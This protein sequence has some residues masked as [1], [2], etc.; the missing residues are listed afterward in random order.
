MF[1]ES[2]V[3]DDY[4]ADLNRWMQTQGRFHQSVASIARCDIKALE[5]TVRLRSA[6]KRAAKDSA[7]NPWVHKAALPRPRSTR[8]GGNPKPSLSAYADRASVASLRKLGEE[9]LIGQADYKPVEFFERGLHVADSVGRINSAIGKS[10]TG[11]LVGEGILM[12]NHHVIGSPEEGGISALTMNLE[13]NIF[14]AVKPQEEFKL[15]PDAF[16]YTDAELDVTLVATSKR[17]ARGTEVTTFGYLPLIRAEGKILR[18]WNVNII[19]HPNEG[20]KVVS[21]RNGV[22]VEIEGPQG[23]DEYCY[24]TADTGKGSSGSPVFNDSWE[25]VAL[26]HHALPKLDAEGHVLDRQGTRITPAEALADPSR[27]DWVANE[28]TRVSRIVAAFET[29]D[30]PMPFATVRDELLKL[31][32]K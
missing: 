22:L 31:W 12:T 10:G 17:S 23:Q 1:G 8:K 20:N 11:F 2:S 21:F 9:A 18:G 3:A 25:V 24:Y 16:F 5:S 7:M 15:N 32:G 26:H 30:L 4:G 19:Q 13:E 6:I 29:A 14:G 28:G 27:V